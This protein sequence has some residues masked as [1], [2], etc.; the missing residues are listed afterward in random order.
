M[1]NFIDRFGHRECGNDPCQSKI[2]VLI[3]EMPS[4]TSSGVAKRVSIVSGIRSRSHLSPTTEPEDG[5]PWIG[6]ILDHETLG[7]EAVRIWVKLGILSYGPGVAAD[8][9]E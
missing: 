5:F 3:P 4:G 7:E 1:T 8:Q 2:H 9:L 6:D